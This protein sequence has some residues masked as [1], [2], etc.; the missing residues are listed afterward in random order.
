MQGF[1]VAIVLIDALTTLRA[2]AEPPC[3]PSII[4]NKRDIIPP[5]IAIVSSD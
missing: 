5:A 2:N 4:P 3:K 1:S